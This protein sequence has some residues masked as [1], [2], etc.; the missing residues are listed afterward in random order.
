MRGEIAETAHLATRRAEVRPVLHAV[1]EGSKGP[2]VVEADGTP[3]VAVQ[4]RALEQALLLLVNNAHDAS[5]AGA[6]VTLRVA[7]EAG[8]VSFAVIDAGHGMPDEVLRQAENPVLHDQ[9]AGQGDGPGA[10]PGAADGRPQQ[11]DVRDRLPPGSGDDGR[12][13]G[14]AGVSGSVVPQPS[15]PS[16][17]PSS[18]W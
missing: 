11:R 18:R 4:P 17:R 12:P 5:P 6:E 8:R 9:A 2:L 7:H 15:P 13:D 14:P 16:R 1:A 3:D 10:V